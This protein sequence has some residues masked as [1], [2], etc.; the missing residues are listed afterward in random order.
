[1]VLG[2][3]AIK[4]LTVFAV[5]FVLGIVLKFLNLKENFA[6]NNNNSIVAKIGNVTVHN[7]KT[8]KIK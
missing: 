5:L 4:V 7:N 6:N 1:M 2:K 3:H 8:I